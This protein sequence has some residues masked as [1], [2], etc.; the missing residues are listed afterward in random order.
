MAV[1]RLAIL[2]LTIWCTSA[3][4]A[5]PFPPRTRPGCLSG[6]PWA[7]YQYRPRSP[8]ETAVSRLGIMLR[9]K[10]SV[11]EATSPP[12]VKLRREYKDEQTF[13][14]HEPTADRLIERR[15]DENIVGEQPA[16]EELDPAADR[17][18]VRAVHATTDE[19]G[20]ANP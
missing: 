15:I 14:Y 6:I 1:N 11:Q 20:E 13:R 12:T 7:D 8:S 18:A 17:E 4:A 2:V 3:V 9:T 5:E 16:I 10:T 19:S